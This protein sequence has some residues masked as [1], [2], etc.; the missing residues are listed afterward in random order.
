MMDNSEVD[1]GDKAMII[2]QSLICY[3]REKNVL[4]RSDIEELKD[5]VEARIA[6]TETH[7]PCATA[8]AAAAATEM[9]ELDD[10]CG[11]RYGGKH[12]RRVN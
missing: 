3:L 8:I 5:R 1:S 6:A 9:R 2:L 7:L 10:Y 11:K 12:R 4:S